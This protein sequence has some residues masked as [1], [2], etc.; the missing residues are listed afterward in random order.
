[1]T[2]F[3]FIAE[4]DEDDE[5]VTTVTF[6]TH[7]WTDTF[8]KYLQFLRGAGFRIKTDPEPSMIDTGVFKYENDK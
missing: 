6:K 3:T 1:M 7:V 8:S 4:E 2:K 5:Q